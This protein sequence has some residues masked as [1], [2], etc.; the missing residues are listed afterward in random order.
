[1]LIQPSLALPAIAM[2][3]NRRSAWP[4][5]MIGITRNH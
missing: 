4:V 1:L 5:W 3:R 2:H